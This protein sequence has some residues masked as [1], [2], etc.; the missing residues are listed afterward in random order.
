MIL[1]DPPALVALLHP[2]HSTRTLPPPI[3][4]L[5]P[6]AMHEEGWR[7][8]THED[9]PERPDFELEGELAEIRRVLWSYK[10]DCPTWLLQRGVVLQWALTDRTSVELSEEY[11]A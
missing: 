1:P 7:R 6:D 11:I 2:T 5:I 3:R 4:R 10:E 8:F 9:I